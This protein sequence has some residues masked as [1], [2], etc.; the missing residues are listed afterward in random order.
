MGAGAQAYL[1]KPS[2]PTE[3]VAAVSRLLAGADESDRP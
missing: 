1:L 3:L 2:E